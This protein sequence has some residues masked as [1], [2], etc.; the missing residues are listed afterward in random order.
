MRRCRRIFRRQKPFV[1]IKTIPL[2]KHSQNSV[3]FHFRV[4]VERARISITTGTRLELRNR[5]GQ[6]V[7]LVA[8]IYSC[9]LTFKKYSMPIRKL[10]IVNRYNYIIITIFRIQDFGF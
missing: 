9:T 5:G 1:Y 7:Y 3:G 2:T 10:C 8:S 6:N 4:F